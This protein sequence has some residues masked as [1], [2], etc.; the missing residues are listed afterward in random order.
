MVLGTAYLLI[1]V[2]QNGTLDSCEFFFLCVTGILNGLLDHNHIFLN[3]TLYSCE[4]F[5][6]V[7]WSFEVIAR[8]PIFSI[9]FLY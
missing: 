9:K 5:M 1:S 6:Y 3:R 8:P 7:L 2:S 4:S